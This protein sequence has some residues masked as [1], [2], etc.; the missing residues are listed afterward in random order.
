MRMASPSGFAL[1]LKK[2]PL[3][4]AFFVGA[5]WH[6]PA[7]A[8]CPLPVKPEQVRVRQVVDG[9]TVRLVDGRSVRLI[10]INT[11]EIGRKGRSSEPY[12]EAAKRRLQ[13]LV[14]ASDG[15]VGL[16]PG[17]QAKDKYGRTLAHIYGRN[18]DNL[19]AQ[20]LSEGLGYRVA[21]APNVRLSGC[22]QRAEQAARQ[23]GAGLWRQ[24]PVVPADAIRHPGF[25]VLSGRIMSI[26]RNRGGVWLNLDRAVV[27]QVSARLQRN[28]PASFFANLK[29]RQVEVRG[30]VVDRSRK[31]GLKP[32][33]RRWVLPLTDPSMLARTSG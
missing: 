14:K 20:L 23:A 33:Q 25:A 24:S 19:E 11:P 8:F 18:G 13:A 16:V 4:G 31:G 27:V 26:E 1:L 29:G 12:A 2:A 28:F 7:L 17:V 15:R 32:G 6:L 30:W 10:G 9:D 3:V 5:I 22:Q 21:V